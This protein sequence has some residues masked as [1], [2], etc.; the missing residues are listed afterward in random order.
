M[1]SIDRRVLLGAAGIAGVAAFSK[2]AGAGPLAPPAGPVASTGKTLTEVE[3]R[4]A[5]NSVNTPGDATAQFR[6]TAPGSYYLTGNI[7]GVSG[8]SA[9]VIATGH[10]SLDLM[11]FTVQGAA[12]ALS[13]VL[14]AGF[15]GGI[16]VRNGTVAGFPQSGV[17]LFDPDRAEGCLIEGISS[18]G[19]GG[20]G[21]GAGVNAVVRACQAFGNG[22]T[23]IAAG[24]N[25]SIEGC[26]AQAN[27]GRGFLVGL[28]N[29]LRGC[30]ALENLADG[31]SVNGDG[32]V[33]DCV[34]RGN[35]GEGFQ[36]NSSSAWRCLADQNGASGFF[37]DQHGVISDCAASFNM[38]HGV[39]AE[40]GC[41]I[42]SN[43]CRSNGAASAGAGVHIT[44]E[45]SRVEGNNCV[46]N[47]YGVRVVSAGNLLM[48]NACSGSNTN[49]DIVAGNRYGPIVNITAATAPSASG[50]S[51]P[52]QMASTDPW[53]NFAY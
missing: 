30:S 31:F 6:I 33:V 1:E 13:G 18:S 20:M 35:A 39:R 44:G 11:G 47:H 29:T 16:A 34:A 46:G 24:N 50:N 3:P 9:I 25:S 19:N 41:M 48:R 32:L 45:D 38:Q 51:A 53:A 27:G 10:V 26:V 21:I 8:K 40:S 5:V 15:H 52:S 4:I 37:A 7:T 14:L 28:S 2:L 12:G 17:Q 36:L 42:V 22:D 23:G 49:F 43:L